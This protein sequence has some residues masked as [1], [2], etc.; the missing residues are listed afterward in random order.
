M[1]STNLSALADQFVDILNDSDPGYWSDIVVGDD[2]MAVPCVDPT[3]YFENSE[4]AIYIVPV[5]VLYSIEGSKGRQKKH[6]VNRGP[7]IAVVMKTPIL[8]R[9][10]TGRDVS[11]WVDAKKY[12]DLR[13]EIDLL[14]IGQDW[15]YNLREVTAEPVQEIP[16]KVRIMLSVTEYEFEGM[17][18]TP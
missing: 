12:M 11:P 2:I 6:S 5:T 9:D 3:T 18:C 16:L 1:P 7:V 8:P 4:S 10:T 14:L 15:G 13:E 17:S